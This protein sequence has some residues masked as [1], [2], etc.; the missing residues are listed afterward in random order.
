ML[1]NGCYILISRTSCGETFINIPVK[2]IG[3]ERYEN[4]CAKVS[5]DMDF[6]EIFCDRKPEELL[7][8]LDEVMQFIKEHNISK[9]NQVTILK[10]IE[11][12]TM[13]MI[14]HD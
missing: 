5:D 9:V 3:S 2:G 10:F 12:H 13:E 6:S 1:K 11:S 14:E 7:Y 4:M 8:D